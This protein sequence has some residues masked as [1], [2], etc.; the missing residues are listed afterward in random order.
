MDLEIFTILKWKTSKIN[1]LRCKRFG[2][3]LSFGSIQGLLHS[4]TLRTN[5]TRARW[6]CASIP[7]LSASRSI[8]Q[9]G[10]AL[11]PRWL[12][13]AASLYRSVPVATDTSVFLALH[14][15]CVRFPK[16]ARVLDPYRRPGGGWASYG[17]TRGPTHWCDRPG[18][19]SDPVTPVGGPMRQVES[20]FHA[21]CPIHSPFRFRMI[22]GGPDFHQ[23]Y[24][25]HQVI[26]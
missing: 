2:K 21:S 23:T 3:I 11:S 1:I 14:E 25:P 15:E 10:V 24:H 20:P 4:E 9:C 13:H 26:L 16:C 6:C 8:H 5:H 22:N 19:S 17:P 12:S 18:R 7:F